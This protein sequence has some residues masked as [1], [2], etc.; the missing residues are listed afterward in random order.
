MSFPCYEVMQ[1]HY[2]NMEVDCPPLQLHT[3]VHL[4]TCPCP[5]HRLLQHGPVS[6]FKKKRNTQYPEMLW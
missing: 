3:S 5:R 6:F 4:E 2:G 1:L